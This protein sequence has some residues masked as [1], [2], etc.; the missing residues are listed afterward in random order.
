[1]S[2]LAIDAGTEWQAL[3]RR[4][5][6]RIPCLPA[7]PAVSVASSAQVAER[8]HGGSRPSSAAAS[9]AATRSRQSAAPSRRRR[10]CRCSG[11]IARRCPSAV[12]P[13]HECL[14]S[15]SIASRSTGPLRRDRGRI[16]PAARR[17]PPPRRAQ[18]PAADPRSP[19]AP[20]RGC[21]EDR[22]AAARDPSAPCPPRCARPSRRCPPLRHRAQPAR[23][24]AAGRRHAGRSARSRRH[25]GAGSKRGS[26]RRRQS[27]NSRA[28]SD[29]PASPAGSWR[30]RDRRVRGAIRGCRRRARARCAS[31]VALGRRASSASA[32]SRASGTLSRL[33]R[34]S[35]TRS[36]SAPAAWR[37]TARSIRPVAGGRSHSP[38]PSEFAAAEPGLGAEVGFQLAGGGLCQTGLADAA[39]PDDR[40]P[41]A[42]LIQQALAQRRELGSAPDQARSGRLSRWPRKARRPGSAGGGR[43]R[44][45]VGRH[46]VAGQPAQRPRAGAS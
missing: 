46:R 34:I 14:R 6:C 22:R 20:R 17:R 30:G 11:C 43:R 45:T 40:Q 28:A 32:S 24:P 37:P 2:V 8:R 21:G 25:D 9:D 4:I 33:S 12:R 26:T 15:I 7:S 44:G 41:A 18:V 31:S 10:N 29:D 16:H 23:W 38:C 42:L 3:V 5:P 19:P 35:S 13:S 1:M 39:R 27:Q 36:E